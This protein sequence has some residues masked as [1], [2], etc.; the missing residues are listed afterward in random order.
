M[1]RAARWALK[2]D[3]IV[4]SGL[5]N[6]PPKVKS[7]I[8]RALR[9]A[10]AAL[11]T[12]S[13]ELAIVLTTDSAIRLLNRQWRG[14]DK[15]TNVL[16]FPTKDARGEPPHIG[17]VVLAYETVGREA[18]DQGKLFADHLAHLAV[19]GYLHLLGYDHQ[20]AKEAEVM[21]R[22]E[23]AILCRLDVPDPYRPAAK[24]TK[25]PGRARRSPTQY[26]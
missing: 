17:D 14:I 5:W 9:A 23:R 4:E 10:A 13:A 11:S 24:A 16:S 2:I 6:E 20:R 22:I 8:R 12:S 1:A 7:L 19:H 18:R 26:R 3:L 21:E 25:P 15:A